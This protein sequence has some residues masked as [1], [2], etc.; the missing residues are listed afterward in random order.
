MYRAPIEHVCLHSRI[1][2][3][4][5]VRRVQELGEAGLYNLTCLFILLAL[6]ADIENVVSFLFPFIHF[7]LQYNSFN[8]V[9]VLLS[10]GFDSLT[11]L[12]MYIV[13]KWLFLCWKKNTI[14]EH[15]LILHIFPPFYSTSGHQ[16]CLTVWH[17][18]LQQPILCTPDRCMAGRTHTDATVREQGTRHEPPGG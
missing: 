1:Y 15:Q 13:T 18:G 4:L 3:R 5:H 10:G 8:S 12:Y 2:S 17:V 9:P 16:A 11:L 6:T 7:Q 14:F